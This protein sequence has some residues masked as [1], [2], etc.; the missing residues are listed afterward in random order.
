[1]NIRY[2][3][4][5]RRV[6]AGRPFFHRYDDDAISWICRCHQRLISDHPPRKARTGTTGVPWSRRRSSQKSSCPTPTW[7]CEYN[8][9]FFAREAQRR[10]DSRQGSHVPK[11]R[12]V[13]Y[14]SRARDGCQQTDNRYLN[15]HSHS[16]SLSPKISRKEK[17]N[18]QKC[19]PPNKLQQTPVERLLEKSSTFSTKLQHCWYA[20]A[21]PPLP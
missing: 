10:S 9:S 13:L 18:S 12:R 11:A 19:Q 21:T 8:L 7:H 14:G 16:I 1:M 6:S 20:A 5:I 17:E 2:V 15:D 4:V 3:T